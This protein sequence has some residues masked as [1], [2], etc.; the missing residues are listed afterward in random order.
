MRPLGLLLAFSAL[1]ADAQEI[2]DL[3][4]KNGHVID[5]KNG[6]NERL[7]VA[8]IG[9]QI[10]RV[11]RDLP[12]ARARNVIDAG[13]YYVTP[14]LIDI[15]ASLDPGGAGRGLNPD[16][17]ML[18]HGVTTAVDA[19]SADGGTFESFKRRVI[20]RAVVRLLAFLDV[21]GSAPA[22]GPS[23][24]SAGEPDIGA[25]V[26]TA[27]RHRQHVVG[28]KAVVS[29][30]VGW[31][32]LER[33]IQAAVQSGGVVLADWQGASEDRYRE[34]VVERLRPG[35]IV[36]P[37]YGRLNPW[38]G[39]PDALPAYL[40]DARRRGVFFDVAHG[41]A[42]FWFRVAAP[43]LERGFLADTVSSGLDRESVMLPGA[44]LAN[45]MSKLLNLGMT[46]EQVIERTTVNA[47][48]AIRR[49]ELGTLGE[50]AEA[51]IAVLAL[52]RGQFAFLDSG[53]AK[54][55]GGVRLRGALTVRAGKV[56]W[57]YDGLDAE[58]WQ[59]AGPYSQFK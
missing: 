38:A 8:V 30:S 36:G 22:G 52:E 2:Y 44:T 14:G 48:R 20:D 49:P 19:G 54:L 4:I 6:R 32:P 47:A 43:A 46:L 50:G 25:A 39:S 17:N 18:R 13:G 35:D 56:V 5:P 27:K 37:I 12:A 29:D 3:L 11:G 40:F 10:A 42:G 24:A 31:Q 57:D 34:L 41:S 9:S 23:P 16:H 59:E 55:T 26:E 21:T 33:A 28:F 58:D 45:V 7:D 53:R 51:D 15:H 1:V